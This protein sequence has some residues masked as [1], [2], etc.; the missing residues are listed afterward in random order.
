[1]NSAK[2][3]LVTGGSRGIGASIIEYFAKNNYNVVINYVTEKELIDYSQEVI[4][5]FAS[6]DKEANTLK[7]KCEQKY[8]VET[9]LIK[10]DVSK[11]VQVK[12]M[13]EKIIKKFGRIDVLVNNA[14]IVIDKEF[15]DRTVKNFEETLRVNVIGTFLVSKYVSKYMLKAK[16]GKIINA[17]S[18]NGLNTV[19]PTS[20]DYDA[21]KAALISL[22]KNMAIEFAPYINVNATALSWANTEMNKQLPEE[23]LKEEHNKILLHR[24]AEPE[25]VAKLVYFLASN[26]ANYITGEV[27]RIDGGMF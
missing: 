6:S 24:F 8:G 2:V 27:I 16:K 4:T 14:A 25:E 3:V 15:A 9:L 19:Y 17:S 26:D 20:I 11:E 1:M 21:S 18:T 12:N 10:A 23:F 13:V 22:T 7:E 5:N